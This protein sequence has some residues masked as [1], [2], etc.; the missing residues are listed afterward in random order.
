MTSGSVRRFEE[1]LRNLLSE[2]TDGGATTTHIN[3]REVER[4]G[5]SSGMSSLEACR[6]FFAFRGSMWEVNTGSLAMSTINSEESGALPPPRN[7]LGIN[8]IYLIV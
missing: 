3:R 2:R 6:Q 8:D 7:W 4:I 1:G 5:E